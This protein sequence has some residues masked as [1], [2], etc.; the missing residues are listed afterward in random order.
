MKQEELGP[1]P[2][3]DEEVEE[4]LKGEMEAFKQ[5]GDMPS[6]RSKRKSE[7]GPA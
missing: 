4:E 2:G 6:A 5:D 3:T 7:Y 1:G